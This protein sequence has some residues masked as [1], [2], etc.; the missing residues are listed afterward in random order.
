[1]KSHATAS[2]LTV[3]VAAFAAMALLAP[4]QQAEAAGGGNAGT[5]I[6]QMKVNAGLPSGATGKLSCAGPGCPGAK[7]SGV[8]ATTTG[9][10]EQCRPGSGGRCRK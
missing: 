3:A 10:K 9:T 7:A 8:R 2:I 4:I 6:T 5:A 1:M